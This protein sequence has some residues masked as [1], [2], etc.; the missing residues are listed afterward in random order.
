M[1]FNG[2]KNQWAADMTGNNKLLGGDLNRTN[3]MNTLD[4][5]ILRTHWYT[6]DPE[7]DI[8]GNGGVKMGDFVIMRT[9]WFQ[10]GDAQ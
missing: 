7:A 1:P 2:G 5:G 6:T 8:D 4:F 10:R 3:T 9:N